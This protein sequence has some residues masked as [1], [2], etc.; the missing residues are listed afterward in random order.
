M[1]RQTGSLTDVFAQF[2]FSKRYGLL[3][4]CFLIMVLSF[5][6]QFCF[7]VFFKPMLNEFGWT[8]AVTSVPFALNGILG[9]LLGILAGRL[10]DRLGP[11]IVVSIGGVVLGAGYLS[12]SQ[13]TNL[14]QFSIFYGIIAAAGF[15]AMYVPLVSMV[16]RWFPEKPGLVAGIGISGIGLGIGVIPVIASTL[17]EISH[18]RT[19]MMI[20]GVICLA[21]ILLLAQML[22]TPPANTEKYSAHVEDHTEHYTFYEALKT[23]QLWMLCLAWFC[24]GFFHHAAL[25]HIVP[26]GTDIGMESTAAAT[27]LTTIGVIGMP[28]RI[29]LGLGGDKFGHKSVFLVAFSACGLIYLGLNCF[30]SITM[31]YVF[32]VIFGLFSGAGVL[33]AP[34]AA[35]HFGA[36]ALGPIIGTI[37]FANTL[38]GAIS[39]VIAGQVFDMTGTYDIAFAVCGIAGITA[40]VTLG[41]LKI[42]EKMRSNH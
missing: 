9:G 26:Y 20:V 16:T 2:H 32:G 30:D 13:V 27:V 19:A 4:A 25:V 17:I 40:A 29:L 15:S 7:G 22:R 8:R 33:A 5:G 6:A 18:W 34:V 23:P 38:G 39:P 3:V 41:L 14:W 21:G 31:L 24:Y 35:E 42:P 10:A 37:I 36:A 28:A 11:R 12:T 1:D